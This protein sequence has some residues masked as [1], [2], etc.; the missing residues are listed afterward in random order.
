M[1]SKPNTLLERHFESGMA[2]EGLRAVDCC[3]LRQEDE[4]AETRASLVVQA[5]AGLAL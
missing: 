1:T 4:E 3:R 2:P 5:V